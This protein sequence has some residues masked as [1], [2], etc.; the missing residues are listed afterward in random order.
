MRALNLVLTVLFQTLRVLGRSRSDP[1][2]ENLALCQQVAVLGRT[3]R[4]PRF[5]ARGW[6]VSDGGES[7][8]NI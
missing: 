5:Q 4:R 3:K 6:R 2:L 1:I 8:V 7:T